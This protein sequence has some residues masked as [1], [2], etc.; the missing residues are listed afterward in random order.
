MTETLYRV[1]SRTDSTVFEGASAREIVKQMKNTQWYAPEG[2]RAY[3][4]EV[5]DRVEQMTG[6][7]FAGNPERSK[8]SKFLEF[9]EAAELVT[10]RK[11]S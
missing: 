9:L 8:P 11:I 5:I 2:K 7:R 1:S 4:A 10:I 3:M 6:M